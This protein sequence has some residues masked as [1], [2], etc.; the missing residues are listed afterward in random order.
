[1]TAMIADVFLQFKMN[2]QKASCIEG[3]FVL[4]KIH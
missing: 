2:K 4:L 1:M 3:L